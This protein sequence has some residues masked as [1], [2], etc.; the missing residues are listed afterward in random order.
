MA[1]QKLIL[2]YEDYQQMPDDRTRKQIIGGDLYVTAAPSPPHQRLVVRLVSI[3]SPHA[4]D[5]GLGEIL[6]SPVD[7][8][9]SQTDV[10]QPDIVFVAAA[11]QRIVGDA[12]IQGAPDLVVEVLSPSTLKLDRERKLDLYA[13]AGIPEYW[14]ADPDSR[15]VEIY[16]LVGGAY[17][18]EG[19]ITEGDVIRSDLFP[20]LAI[21]L[22]SLWD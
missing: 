6:V 10:V 5:R 21:G 17:H 9:L 15:A 8:V 16:R 11:N 22:N 19:R 20:E 12:A 4:R 2:T 14:I 3:L 1:R 7:V 18:L 13:R